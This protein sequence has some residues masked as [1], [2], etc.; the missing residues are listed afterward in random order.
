ME[1]W[2][3]PLMLGVMAVSAVIILGLIL[4]LAHAI[5]TGGSSRGAQDH[6]SG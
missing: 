6:E 4:W 1:S 5:F 3:E 2:T